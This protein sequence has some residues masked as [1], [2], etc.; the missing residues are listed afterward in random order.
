[1]CKSELI[2]ILNNAIDGAN[3]LNMLLDELHDML[4]ENRK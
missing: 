3:K 4:V 2:K 1:M